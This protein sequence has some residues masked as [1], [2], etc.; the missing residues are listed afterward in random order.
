[1]LA[2]VR[3]WSGLQANC[4]KTA[5]QSTLRYNLVRA[6]A[7]SGVLSALR[8]GSDAKGTRRRSISL[9]WLSPT[10]SDPPEPHASDVTCV[11]CRSKLL[12]WFFDAVFWRGLR[13][14]AS[15]RKAIAMIRRP[16]ANHPEPAPRPQ[17]GTDATFLTNART[18]ARR[19]PSTRDAAGIR[20]I[21]FKKDATL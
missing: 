2:L 11:C 6:A 20:N 10:R 18:A 15:N 9:E 12:A 4:I 5:K 7:C 13:V 8:F 14:R 17:K 1:M 3:F 19:H 21:A 16:Q